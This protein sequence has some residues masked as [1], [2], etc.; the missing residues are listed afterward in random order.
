MSARWAA[1]CASPRGRSEGV[2]TAKDAKDAK[3]N[4]VEIVFQCRVLNLRKNRAFMKKFL[5]IVFSF[6]YFASF[7]VKRYRSLN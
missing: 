3:G 5:F 4:L 1:S 7:A 6:V 2:F